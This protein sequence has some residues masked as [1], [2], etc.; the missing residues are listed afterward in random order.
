MVK[1]LANAPTCALG[2]FPRSLGGANPDVLAGND[3]TLSDIAGSVKRVKG[4]KIGCA[5]P[6]TLGCGTG[7]LG[8]PFADISCAAANVATGTAMVVLRLGVRPGSVGWLR[9]RLGLAVL[10]GG[11]LA[12]DDQR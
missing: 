6:D 2:Y 10:G 12:A 7:T 9:R 11:V 4:D 8:G 3:R 5:F 1:Y